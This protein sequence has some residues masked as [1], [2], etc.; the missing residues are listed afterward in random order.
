MTIVSSFACTRAI[1]ADHLAFA[2]YE[3]AQAEKKASA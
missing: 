2:V 1:P 3:K